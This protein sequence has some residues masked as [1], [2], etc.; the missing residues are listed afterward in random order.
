MPWVQA[1][2]ESRRGW[3]IAPSRCA[4]TT[5]SSA[6][7][8]RV[9]ST[10]ESAGTP[11]AGAPPRPG[12]EGQGRDRIRESRSP[13][14]CATAVNLPGG[15]IDDGDG[16]PLGDQ[17]P[18]ERVELVGARG[19]ARELLVVVEQEQAAPAAG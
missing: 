18:G 7:T 19:G 11:P 8:T 2:S 1:Q 5:P 16:G 10:M 6:S 15:T 14:P 9:S 3:L 12:D 17:P 13:P 4:A